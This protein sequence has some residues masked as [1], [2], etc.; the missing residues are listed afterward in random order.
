VFVS[1][2]SDPRLSFTP[3]ADL[4]HAPFRSR[5]VR[6]STRR[7][8]DWFDVWTRAYW[9]DY[10]GPV[11]GRLA[12]AAQ[13]LSMRTSHDALCFSNLHARRLRECGFGG[14]ITRLEGLY[15]GQFVPAETREAQPLVVF[16]GRHIAEKRVRSVVL[17]IALARERVPELRCSIYG[18]GPERPSVLTQIGSAG[19]EGVVSA[20]GAS[21]EGEVEAALRDAPCLLRPTER[22]GY[23]VVVVEAAAAGNTHCAGCRAR[24]RRAGTRRPWRERFGGAVCVRR[25]PGL[26]DHRGSGRR[27]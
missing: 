18:D 24:Q 25:R 23:G 26:S 14:V 22:E 11:A 6:P 1:S 16:V 19:L 4:N 21:G 10:L 5:R 9:F 7:V 20:P 17:A 2:R 15:A 13:R 3:A 8:V 12:W 27:H